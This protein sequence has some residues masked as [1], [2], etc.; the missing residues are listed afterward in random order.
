MGS[1]AYILNFAMAELINKH[2]DWLRAVAV[3]SA[4]NVENIELLKMPENKKN[5][6]VHS[7]DATFYQTRDGV[8]PFEESYTPLVV[9]KEAPF[10]V[11]M[12]TLDPDIKTFHDL[13]GKTVNMLFPGTS[14]HTVGGA[15]LRM[16]GIW[17][18]INVVAGGFSKSKDDL[19]AFT[20][21]AG[22]Q[23]LNFVDPVT[24]T[25]ATEELITTKSTY[26]VNYPIGEEDAVYAQLA[27]EGQFVPFRFDKIPQSAHPKFHNDWVAVVGSLFWLADPEMDDDVLYEFSRILNE[28]QSEMVVYYA[29]AKNWSDE[30]FGDVLVERQYWHPGALKYWDEKGIDIPF[31]EPKH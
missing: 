2:S 14:T 28:Y 27:K 19:L 11:V 6:I 30:H 15:I 24:M 7:T 21:D 17:D 31:K 26:N 29:P 12:V 5:M 16:Y 13:E 18:S 3:E 8:T 22:S 1:S 4:S 10:A 9:A 23:S 25:P 20:I